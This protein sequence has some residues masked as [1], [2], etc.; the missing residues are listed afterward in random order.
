M[1]DSIHSAIADVTDYNERH[2]DLT[3]IATTLQGAGNL[4]LTL[5]SRLIGQRNGNIEH[6]EKCGEG[7]SRGIAA[8]PSTIPTGNKQ[9]YI[10]LLRCSEHEH[11]RCYRLLPLSPSTEAFRKHSLLHAPAVCPLPLCAACRA[12]SPPAS[13]AGSRLF[14]ARSTTL[15]SV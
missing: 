14:L 12:V 8:Q 1:W 3:N 10:Q 5:S 4:L 13:F 2:D 7:V 15:L 9:R 11:N 6:D